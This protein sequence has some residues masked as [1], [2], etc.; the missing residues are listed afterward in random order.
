MFIS[1]ILKKGLNI[2]HFPDIALLLHQPIPNN[3]NPFLTDKTV[4][5]FL[6]EYPL[7]I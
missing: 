6:I 1:V 2:E 3:H 4:T 5:F 7:N